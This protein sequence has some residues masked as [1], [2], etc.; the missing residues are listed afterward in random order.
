MHEALCRI[1]RL[2]LYGI[3]L[4]V[5]SDLSR[6]FLKLPPRD[7]EAA[8][9]WLGLKRQYPRRPLVAIC[10]GAKQPANWWPVERFIEI[11]RRLAEQ[12][13]YELLVVGGAAE[14]QVGERMVTAWGAGLNAAGEFSVLGSAALL[15]QCSFI[16]GLDTGTTHLAAA[17]GVPCVALYGG[18][19]NPGRFEP[20]GQGHIILRHPVPCANCRLI[21]TPCPVQGH[22]CMTGISIE[23]VWTAIQQLACKV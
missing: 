12:N 4:S 11:G 23:A 17:M 19:E 15:G 16:V 22:P 2:R 6:P 13:R 1:E 5:E 18:R 3:D 14:G 21:M 8:K 20:L 10:P 7:V 9:Q